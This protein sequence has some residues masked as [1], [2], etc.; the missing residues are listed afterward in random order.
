V[1]AAAAIGLAARAQ[2]SAAMRRAGR[3]LSVV[4]AGRVSSVQRLMSRR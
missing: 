4:M 1:V 3:D 2:S